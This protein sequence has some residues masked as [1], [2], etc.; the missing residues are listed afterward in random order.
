MCIT[1]HNYTIVCF[2]VC[3]HGYYKYMKIVYTAAETKMTGGSVL[4]DSAERADTPSLKGDGE[5]AQPQ[6]PAAETAV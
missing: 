3:P 2:H 5:R 1:L 6:L 4:I